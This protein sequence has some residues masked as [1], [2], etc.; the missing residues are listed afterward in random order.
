MKIKYNSYLTIIKAISAAALL[1][2]ATLSAQYYWE[3][4]EGGVY[5]IPAVEYNATYTGYGSDG[6]LIYNKIDLQTGESMEIT[7]TTNL[8]D[9]TGNEIA[10][11]WSSAIGWNHETSFR[12][13]G[14]I[15]GAIKDIEIEGETHRM[16]YAWSVNSSIGRHSGWMKLAD[17]SPS[18]TIEAILEDNDE[19]RMAII[20]ASGAQ[21]ATYNE[22]TIVATNLPDY[23]EEYYLDPDRDASYSAGK[24]RYYYTG[25]ENYISGLTN[26]PETGRQRYGVA[27]DAFPLGAKFYY[28]ISVPASNVSIYAPSSSVPESHSLDLVWGYSITSAGDK[29]YSWVNERALEDTGVVINGPEEIEEDK[30]VS[31]TKSNA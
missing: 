9:N 12:D 24:A 5:N 2:P 19:K 10:R 6:D 1:V 29:V 25:D 26:I 3:E 28:D 11:A 30:I 8:Y 18:S 23:M 21:T 27:H 14:I 4:E 13:G 7:Q 31:I 22:A 16:V 20:N 15:A 17:L